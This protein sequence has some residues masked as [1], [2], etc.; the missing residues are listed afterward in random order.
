MLERG[1][2]RDIHSF[3]DRLRVHARSNAL[4]ENRSI[5]LRFGALFLVSDIRAGDDSNA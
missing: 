5:V 2:V 3:H 1:L 4:P